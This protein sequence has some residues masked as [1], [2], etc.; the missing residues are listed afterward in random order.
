MTN[1]ILEKL[2]PME[3]ADIVHGE[4]VDVVKRAPRGAT[5]ILIEVSDKKI[6][7]RDYRR[8]RLE[9]LDNYIGVE[10][11]AYFYSTSS[12][13]RFREKYLMEISAS[14]RELLN[15]WDDFSVRVN[16]DK[17]VS[18]LAIPIFLFLVSI[19]SIEIILRNEREV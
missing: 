11:T 2:P 15:D 6:F 19:F 14:G 9:K 1:D 16:G 3:E 13:L 8:E 12:I 10:V 4:I 5:G 18:Y 17:K 7:L